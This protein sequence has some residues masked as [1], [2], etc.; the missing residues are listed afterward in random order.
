MLL[1]LWG[2]VVLPA[3]QQCL[4]C[5]ISFIKTASLISSI[6]IWQSCSIASRDLQ[7]LYSK[8]AESLEFLTVQYSAR[9]S[10]KGRALDFVL[11]STSFI[12]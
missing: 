3:E 5:L 9:T 4:Q 10:A 2:V 8:A 6:C 12:P 11:L 1:F 7:V